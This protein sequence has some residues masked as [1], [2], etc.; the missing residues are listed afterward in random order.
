L[1]RG[2]AITK[3][4]ARAATRTVLAALTYRTYARGAAAAAVTVLDRAVRA[5]RQ[6]LL[7][8]EWRLVPAAVVLLAAMPAAHVIALPTLIQQ[9]AAAVWAAQAVQ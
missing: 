2:A 4:A 5:V 8:R 1:D 6:I 9:A 7:T 3:V